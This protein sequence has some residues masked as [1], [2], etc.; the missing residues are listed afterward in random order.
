[1]DLSIITKNH[2]ADPEI[3]YLTKLIP[4]AMAAQRPCRKR[5]T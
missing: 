2:G 5:R 1:M 4:E 3:G